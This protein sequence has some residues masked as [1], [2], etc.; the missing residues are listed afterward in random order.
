MRVGRLKLVKEDNMCTR[1]S[2]RCTHLYIPIKK[3]E[4]RIHVRMP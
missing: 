2:Y 1:T 4:V 3:Q